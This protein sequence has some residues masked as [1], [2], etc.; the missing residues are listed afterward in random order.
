MVG[1]LFGFPSSQPHEDATTSK[2]QASTLS[3]CLEVTQAD[4]RKQPP[5]FRHSSCVVHF[6]LHVFFFSFSLPLSICSAFAVSDF[7]IFF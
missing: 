5:S 1:L 6:N 7:S 3:P 4:N 2:T